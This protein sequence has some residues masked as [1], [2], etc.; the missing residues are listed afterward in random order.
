MRWTPESR[1]AQRQRT[2]KANGKRWTP[3]AREAQRQKMLGH[4][5]SREARDK[6]RKARVGL[7]MNSTGYSSYS[8]E[9][10]W[11]SRL[12][13]RFRVTPEWFQARLK[14][15]GGKCA[16]CSNRLGYGGRRLHID[17]D[18]ACCPTS[19]NRYR[20][21]GKCVRGLLCDGCN[22]LLGKVEKTG[23]FGWMERAIAYLK[24]YG[25][26]V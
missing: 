14:K 22:T 7:I 5:V 24:E 10:G 16:L 26:K 15:Q 3:E 4:E 2:I 9:Y 12:K 25:W 6:I 23:D 13:H 1:E 18:H 20:T 21:C 19:K 8:V 17:H 11:I